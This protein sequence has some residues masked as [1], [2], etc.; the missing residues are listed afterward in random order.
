MRRDILKGHLEPLLLA[1]LDQ[2]D[3]HGYLIMEK[4]RERSR[5]ELDLPEGTIYPILRRLEQRGSVS[6][7]WDAAS[8]RKHRMYRLTARG[9]REL[10]RSREEW[11]RCVPAVSS[12]LGGGRCPIAAPSRPTSPISP[13]GWVGGGSS[14]DGPSPSSATTSR[15]PPRQTAV[16]G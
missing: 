9:R 4:L 7:R 1:C 3:A 10:A 11:T 8:G 16:A 6:S 13:R 2:A 15:P 12:V 14:H 5:G